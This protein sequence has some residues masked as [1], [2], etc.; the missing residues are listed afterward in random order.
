MAV[1]GT[2]SGVELD[3]SAETPQV[4]NLTHGIGTLT[5]D[6]PQI[7]DCI[8]GEKTGEQAKSPILKQLEYY[9]SDENYRRDRFLQENADS[10]RWILCSVFVNFPKIKALGVSQPEELLDFVSPSEDIEYKQD[11]PSLRRRYP[12]E[13]LEADTRAMDVRMQELSD[14]FKNQFSLAKEGFSPRLLL[15]RPLGFL[16]GTVASITM[17]L[18]NQKNK[19]A[20][21]I[22]MEAFFHAINVIAL[23]TDLNSRTEYLALLLRFASP[24]VKLMISIIGKSK[25]DKFH[26]EV[27]SLIRSNEK[28]RAERKQDARK[29]GQPI[30]KSI[31]HEIARE[32]DSFLSKFAPHP[33]KEYCLEASKEKLRMKLEAHI[34]KSGG[35]KWTTCKLHAYGSSM[36]SLGFTSS[37]LDLCCTVDASAWEG[38]DEGDIFANLVDQLQGCENFCT[39]VDVI[40]TARVPIVKLHQKSS[41]I[42]CDISLNHTLPLS[43]TLLL[44]TYA[45]VD[46]RVRAL[47]LLVKRWASNRGINDASNGTLSSY[48]WVIMVLY[49]L[50][51][52]TPPILPSLQDAA[53]IKSCALPNSIEI[54]STEGYDIQFC[55]DASLARNYLQQSLTEN[56]K[57]TETITDLFSRFFDF[58]A[59]RFNTQGNVVSI[60]TTQT[61]SKA[62]A[63]SRMPRP[64]TWRI[65][66]EDP[67]EVGHDLASVIFSPE[68]NA[69]LQNE[70]ARSSKVLHSPLNSKSILEELWEP[71]NA[72]SRGGII[73]FCC[74]QEGH[75]AARCAKLGRERTDAKESSESEHETNDMPM[76][77]FF[78]FASPCFSCGE[79][80][81]VV[82]KCKKKVC[83]LCKQPGHLKRNCPKLTRSRETTSRSQSSKG[84]WRETER[85]AKGQPGRP[86]LLDPKHSNMKETKGWRDDLNESNAV[87]QVARSGTDNFRVK[88][89]QTNHQTK[90][91][92]DESMAGSSQPKVH[93]ESGGYDKRR[94]NIKENTLSSERK[95][96]SV[97]D[98]LGEKS[99]HN[100]ERDLEHRKTASSAGRNRGRSYGGRSRSRGGSRGGRSR[101]GRSAQ[102]KN[103]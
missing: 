32:I 35:D 3:A 36:T 34:K 75:V 39:I 25:S 19:L 80:D 86:M 1:Y 70:L 52:R 11:P 101:G 4:G 43:N 87:R 23:V 51:Q 67:I 97:F 20:A 89:R 15:R 77:L 84:N 9:F 94:V 46:A 56:G 2:E 16:I 5:T 14:Y 8:E 92:G 81:H 73:C 29:S 59:F 85:R 72:V 10:N 41:G 44:Q 68:A 93:D 95:H 82:S 48:A 47:V 18:S 90:E 64:A 55:K 96:V 17:D 83:F 27:Q 61:L 71:K 88:V 79:C 102:S 42:E 62:K 31:K 30:S 100:Q 7:L 21:P 65:S 78:T 66:I 50:Q 60:R 33:D 24:L 28:L 26:Q 99:M 45:Q 53:L 76:Y 40:A 54:T 37:D 49:F 103:V 98:R 13:E 38:A 22:S 58:Y 63:D 69:T 57:N 6:D 12:L 91:K 74:G